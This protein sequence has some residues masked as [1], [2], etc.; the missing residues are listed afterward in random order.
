M[1]VGGVLEGRDED[2]GLVS[3]G[4]A[5]ENLDHGP[6]QPEV[7][8]VQENQPPRRSYV[9]VVANASWPAIDS[10]PELIQAG[11]IHR[12]V[13][14]QQDYESKRQV[15]RFA[16]I[17]RVN[18]RLV[19]L[20]YL[21]KEAAEKW[22]LNQGVTM[23]PLGKGYVIF[24]FHCERDKAAIWKR[25]PFKLGGQL[26]RFQHWTPDFNIY[27]KQAQAKLI[28]VRFPD[29]PLEYWYENVLLSIAKV[30]GRPMALDQHTRQGLM[31]YYARVLVEMDV[32]DMPTRVDEVQVERLEPDTS[33]MFGFRQKV[34]YEDIG[35]SCGY[36]KQWATKSMSPGR[37]NWQMRRRHR[38]TGQPPFLVPSM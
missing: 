30:V 13:I 23:P 32:S 38:F 19:S 24:E 6:V 36:C 15:F 25:S 34:V 21:R 5:R 17:G 2:E 27:E 1:D 4:A 11:N 26:I 16:L 33:K 31:G 37:K 29:L 18:F 7:A 8:L 3:E 20:D 35:G 12:I 9:K 14:P 22:N 28:W 10:L